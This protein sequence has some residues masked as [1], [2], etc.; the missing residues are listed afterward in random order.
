MKRIQFYIV[1]VLT[2]LFAVIFVFWHYSSQSL[3]GKKSGESAMANNIAASD[4]NAPMVNTQIPKE[5]N[6]QSL[7][8]RAEI[9]AMENQTLQ[10]SIKFT[11]EQS[12]KL[13]AER[14]R[15]IAFFGKVVDEE[16][17]AVAGASVHFIWLTADGTPETD[18]AS[19]ADG[20][21]SLTGVKG[22]EVSVY[23]SKKDYYEIKSLNGVTFDNTG[24]GSSQDTPV[25]FHLRKKGSGADLVTSQFGIAKDFQFSMPRDGTP[26]W[27]DFFN[28][29]IGSEGQMELTAIK[30]PNGQSAPEWSFRLTIPDGGLIENN[31][32][33]PFRAPESGYQSTIEFRFKNDDPNWGKSLRKIFYI[34]FGQPA[35]YGRIT[36][37]TAVDMGVISTYAINPSGSRNLEATAPQ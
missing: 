26:V 5:Q 17:Q 4:T 6:K 27:L 9:D 20:S 34:V 14:N 15:P 13:V 19:A 2:V 33:F 31:D 37:E 3:A 24:N 1:L 23:V 18:A 30:P 11:R 7:P 22:S 8:T 29:K 10:K 32:E 28:R 25:L 21:F 16:T 36:I 12:D 35:K